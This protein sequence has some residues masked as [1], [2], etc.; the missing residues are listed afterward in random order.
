MI[1]VSVQDGQIRRVGAQVDT[2]RPRVDT[3]RPIRTCRPIPG[4]AIDRLQQDLSRTVQL[5]CVRVARSFS[6][7]V[8][9]DAG[10]LLP[11]LRGLAPVSGGQMPSSCHERPRTSSA[12]LTSREMRRRL[13]AEGSRGPR[14]DRENCHHRPSM[15]ATRPSLSIAFRSFWLMVFISAAFVASPYRTHVNPRRSV[16]S[17]APLACSMKVR[18]KPRTLQKRPASK[19]TLSRGE[20]WPEPAG[21]EAGGWLPSSRRGRTRTLRSPL[22]A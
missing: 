14:A 21:G 4:G 1:V 19:T 16:G 20:A 2:G 3:L 22:H 7:P 17:F 12:P 6:V 5:R 18:R 8:I 9:E 10:R 13:I 11:L 15:R